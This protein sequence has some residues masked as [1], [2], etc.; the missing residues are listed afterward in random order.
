MNARTAEGELHLGLGSLP[1]GL[2]LLVSSDEHWLRPGARELLSFVVAKMAQATYTGI[3]I[4]SF[5]HRRDSKEERLLDM[6]NRNRLTLF[7]LEIISSLVAQLTSDIAERLNCKW[8]VAMDGPEFGLMPLYVFGRNSNLQ[9]CVAET[10]TVLSGQVADID[11][12]GAVVMLHDSHS[13]NWMPRILCLLRVNSE[14]VAVLALGSRTTADGY[15]DGDRDLVEAHVTNFCFLLSN[16]RLAAKIGMEMAQSQRTRRELENAREVQQ[17]LLPCKLPGIHGLDYYGE[18]QPV[19]EVGGDFFDFISLGNSSLLLSIGDVSGKGIPSAMIMAAV[20]GSLRALESSMDFELCKLMHNL[21][22]MVW[23]LAP[24]YFFAT[25]FCARVDV[26]TREMHYVNA[27]H[28][29][30]VLLRGDKKRALTLHSTG[31]VLGLSN[32]TVFE[33]R[34][35]RLEPGDTLVA[36]TDGIT[37]AADLGGSAFDRAVLDGLRRRTAGSARDLAEHIIQAAQAHDGD[38]AAPQDDQTVVVVRRI[39]DMAEAV[40]PIPIRPRTLAY[41]AGL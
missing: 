2:A 40:L 22:R 15:T 28:D 12:S 24:D 9:A 1:C 11:P 35:I 5:R 38:V 31:A 36:V 30:A 21:N 4:F 13:E 8:A 41:A 3:Q 17:R 27:G 25:M 10:N 26:D 33:Q 32:R 14:I 20:Q 18:S 7:S 16:E 34:T 6:S 29:R 19:G 39:E 37:E 23:Q